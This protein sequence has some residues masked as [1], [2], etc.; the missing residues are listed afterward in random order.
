MRD[1]SELILIELDNQSYEDSCNTLMD[2]LIVAPHVNRPINDFTYEIPPELIPLNRQIQRLA[3]VHGEQAKNFAAIYMYSFF[4]Q[5]ARGCHLIEHA[6]TSEFF[7][8]EQNAILF[9]H[10]GDIFFGDSALKNFQKIDVLGIDHTLFRE[11]LNYLNT[12]KSSKLMRLGFEIRQFLI[13]TVL[14][15]NLYKLYAAGIEFHDDFYI[16][17]KTTNF[18]EFAIDHGSMV[19]FRFFI[20]KLGLSLND[21]DVEITRLHP[22]SYAYQQLIKTVNSARMTRFVVRHIIELQH[23]IDYLEQYAPS[24]SRH[25]ENAMMLSIIHDDL[26]LFNKYRHHLEADIVVELTDT[27]KRNTLLQNNFHI[28]VNPDNTLSLGF[29]SRVTGYQHVAI[30][31]VELCDWIRDHIARKHTLIDFK[32]YPDQMALI[33]Q[34]IR[35][36]Q[37]YYLS[38]RFS[39]YATHVDKHGYTPFMSAVLYSGLLEQKLEFVRALL[40]STS[41]LDKNSQGQSIYHLIFSSKDIYSRNDLTRCIALLWMIQFIFS[42]EFALQAEQFNELMRTNYEDHGLLPL[43]AA[44]MAGQIWFVEKI[45]K[46]DPSWAHVLTLDNENLLFCALA[47]N[48]LK[49]F[50]LLHQTYHVS[51]DQLNND[52]LSVKHKIFS[53]EHVEFIEY[54]KAAEGDAF[55]IHYPIENPL[56]FSIK[57]NQLPWFVAQGGFDFALTLPSTGQTVLHYL[58]S[59][60]QTQLVPIDAILTTQPELLFAVD[61]NGHTP[62]DAWLK[63]RPRIPADLVFMKAVI[64]SLHPRYPFNRFY[65]AYDILLYCVENTIL[66]PKQ[67]LNG[68]PLFH[69]LERSAHAREMS[70]NQ[71]LV[72]VEIHNISVNTRDSM[73]QHILAKLVNNAPDSLVRIRRLLQLFPHYELEALDATGANLLHLAC[74]AKNIQVI[75]WLCQAKLPKNFSKYLLHKR[76]DDSCA[77]DVVFEQHDPILSP[78]FWSRLTDAKKSKYLASLNNHTIQ[79]FLETHCFFGWHHP[80]NHPSA[81]LT[82]GGLLDTLTAGDILQAIESNDKPLIKRLKN[83][84]HQHLWEALS[85]EELN[86]V[87]QLL[88]SHKKNPALEQ[89]RRVPYLMSYPIAYPHLL[90]AIQDDNDALVE[91]LLRSSY[92]LAWLA[93]DDGNLLAIAA[94]HGHSHLVD[95]L[96][97][98]PAIREHA[99]ISEQRAL[100]NALKIKDGYSCYLLLSTLSVRE[101]LHNTEFALLQPLM[102][103]YQAEEEFACTVMRSLAKDPW[104]RE[105]YRQLPINTIPSVSD[106]CIDYSE[107]AAPDEHDLEP[108]SASPEQGLNAIALAAWWFTSDLYA[109]RSYA[110]EVIRVGD[111]AIL[112]SLINFDAFT[113]SPVILMD[114]VKFYNRLVC[115]AIDYQ[116]PDIAWFL[117]D[118][119]IVSG[120]QSA[121]HNRLLRRSIVAGYPALSHRLLDNPYVAKH[122]HVSNNSALRW[123]MFHHLDDVSNRLWMLTN[124][125]KTA[126]VY[127]QKH[128]YL[129]SLNSF[130]AAKAN[131]PMTEC[132]Y[133]NVLA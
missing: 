88:I 35:S 78:Q 84:S 104:W 110:L 83:K 37:G 22:L 67:L 58:L 73:N 6:P 50:K 48:N 63:H 77:L 13:A 128:Q 39:N 49:L 87:W 75:Q 40:T 81:D 99:A 18:I 66:Q 31:Q 32:Q 98:V 90:R 4:H 127:W 19:L 57:E 86:K 79:S 111:F 54:I 51:L 29:C 41:R 105:H 126:A 44:I 106:T 25:G 85:V 68:E 113:K 124:V 133:L 115:E 119:A 95:R 52:R 2:Q 23:I 5:L 47:V 10:H 20:D 130:F 92:V 11:G 129:L 7:G 42:N 21:A 102:A 121:Y 97:G 82:Q 69:V 72:D 91:Q 16:S 60:G 55:H 46:K 30:T 27:V 74:L 28:L 59:S 61:H 62:I 103:S 122:A 100:R 15:P 8:P 132:N 109:K 65:Y 26:D 89:L 34:Y 94:E 70:Y 96:L 101:A 12:K 117:M 38:L 43:H 24:Y 116:K 36:N 107:W 17:P 45:L 33:H 53:S 118:N 131:A 108:Y 114:D 9:M 76:S 123:A 71:L 56:I 1:L 120:Y 93:H 64:Q 125:Q 80:D 14:I 112:R 3:E